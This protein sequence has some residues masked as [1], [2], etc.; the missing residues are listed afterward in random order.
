MSSSLF[1]NMINGGTRRAERHPKGWGY[2]DW[3]VNGERYCGKILHFEKGKKCSIHY[4]I[5]KDE[6]F[7]LLSGKLEVLLAD[8]K[9]LYEKGE[10]NNI[11]MNPG[12]VLYIWPGRV[13]RMKGLV[14]SELMEI[15]T[16]HFEDDSYR[17]LRG[18]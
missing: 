7:Y 14:E 3:I 4:H 9:E 2:E 18:D 17:I 6:T 11:L 12:E 10:V 8:S 5:I 13:H 15:S 1:F 16:Q